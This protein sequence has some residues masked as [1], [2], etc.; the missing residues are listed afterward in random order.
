MMH[1][2]SCDGVGTKQFLHITAESSE[3]GGRHAACT[4]VQRLDR[5]GTRRRKSWFADVKPRLGSSLLRQVTLHGP[6]ANFSEL[7]TAII[8]TYH[9]VLHDV[10]HG[11]ENPRVRWRFLRHVAVDPGMFCF[12]QPV[13]LH[14]L[15][16]TFTGKVT[17]ECIVIRD[18]L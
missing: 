15:R 9:A 5:V 13:C 14:W 12:A 8:L 18:K 7:L 4:I 3:K 2:R 11:S 1:G 10:S 17:A 6:P 16:F